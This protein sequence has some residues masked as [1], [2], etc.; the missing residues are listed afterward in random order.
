VDYVLQVD[1]CGLPVPRTI[2]R[3][4]RERS[5][6]LVFGPKRGQWRI[7]A[8]LAKEAQIKQRGRNGAGQGSANNKIANNKGQQGQRAASMRTISIFLQNAGSMHP[9][10]STESGGQQQKNSGTDS[11]VE[12]EPPQDPARLALPISGN[13]VDALRNELAILQP[14]DDSSASDQV[15]AKLIQGPLLLRAVFVSMS[16]TLLILQN[17]W[18][19]H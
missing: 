6:K 3:M 10:A 9:T 2:A 15:A 16:K 14:I 7:V 13:G 5:V 11:H 4:A 19:L 17:C 8:D 18:E 1:E 12:P